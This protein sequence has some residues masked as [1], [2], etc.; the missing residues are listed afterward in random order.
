MKAYQCI[1]GV[2]YTKAKILHDNLDLKE[3]LSMDKNTAMKKLIKIKG[4]GQKFAEKICN[5]LELP[6]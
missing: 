2:G 3:L 5:D 1:K 6:E 4:I